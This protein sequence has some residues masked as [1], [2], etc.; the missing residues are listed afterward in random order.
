MNFFYNQDKAR[1][2]T[3]WLVIGFI[4]SIV[5]IVLII[6]GVILSLP[7]EP[8]LTQNLGYINLGLA[9]VIFLGSVHKYT[10]LRSGG[11]SIVDMLNATPIDRASTD[12]KYRQ[13]VNVVDEIAIASGIASPMLYVL[14]QEVGINAFVAG[15]N[16]NDT[17]LVVTQGT[18]NNL[19]RDE[20]QGVIAHEYSHIF[21]SDTTLNLRILVVLSGLFMVSQI[22]YIM[23]R[24]RGDKKGNLILIGLALYIIGYLGVLFGNIIRA[25]ISRERE[26][27][28]DASAVQYT[29][30]P[31]GI[32]TALLKI[33]QQGKAALMQNDHAEDVNHMCFSK[34]QSMSLT[35]I[36]ATH[37]KLEKRIAA[38]DPDGTIT[39]QFR[40]SE[41]KPKQ[42]RQEK[43]K[44]KSIPAEDFFVGAA[45]IVG[46][47]IIASIGNPSSQSMVHAKQILSDIPQ[48]LKNMLDTAAEAQA[49]MY[50]IIMA[51]SSK[52]D[53]TV[54]SISDDVKPKIEYCLSFSEIKDHDCRATLLELATP[55]LK[56]MDVATT[57]IFL[58]NLY[59][60]GTVDKQLNVFKA[61]M[62]TILTQRLNPNAFKNI[63]PR[64]SSFI[65]V[66]AEIS[67]ILWFL[68]MQGSGAAIEQQKAYVTAIKNLDPKF[69]LGLDDQ[70]FS[71]T[72]LVNSL[73]R[74]RLIM[75]AL[76]ERL[77]K[78]CVTCIMQDSQ[79]QI[80]EV[81]LLR[82]VCACL[83]CPAPLL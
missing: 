58:K 48:G 5:L 24:T 78:A 83:D 50:A 82:A 34:A 31:Q 70:S 67:C 26:S 80:D 47:Q 1:R 64:F 54:I 35:D 68:A 20:L 2:K 22:G 45:T 37:P 41:L 39:A 75:P 40:A 30:N 12:P 17:V 74:L 14:P 52:Q 59:A 16:P 56:T 53:Y 76:K 6:N 60:L 15:Y 81:A 55:T 29:R 49:L 44:Q 4:L 18:L 38:L 43:P 23:L 73:T 8:L 72:D 63:T 69:S 51:I 57:E 61:I 10:Q 13:L 3:I 19:S 36:F 11:K 79:A 32:T 33:E 66:R 27:L 71:V 25:A 77:L 46:P 7:P 28:A 65:E 9:A 62:L 21:N 42:E